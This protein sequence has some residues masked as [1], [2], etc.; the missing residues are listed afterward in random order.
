LSNQFDATGATVADRVV[1]ATSVVQKPTVENPAVPDPPK[2]AAATSERR[3]EARYPTQDPAEL[4]ILFSGDETIYG[5]VLDVSRSGMRIAL[6]KRINR[7]EQV[8]V[9]LQQN[10]IFGEIR[11]CRAVP[12]GFQAGLKIQDLVRPPGRSEDHIDDEPLTLYAAGKGLSV[13]EVIEIREHLVRCES[14][15]AQ[16]AG[17]LA[18]LNP[19][20]R[21]NR[22][23]AA[24]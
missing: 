23:P 13:S 22:R 8:K 1:I 16:L 3:R 19:S 5:T 4:E 15:R 18:L 9:K 12:G 17:K 6:S 10:V 24:Y 11:Y 7:G 21:A 2:D 20:R 14:C